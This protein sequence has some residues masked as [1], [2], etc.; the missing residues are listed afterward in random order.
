MRGIKVKL[1]VLALIGG[2]AAIGIAGVPAL[3]NGHSA[4]A[5]SITGPEV[6]YG[7]VHGKAAIVNSPIIPLQW[8]GLVSTHSS[9]NL[10]GGGPHKGSVKTLTSPAGNLTIKVTRKPHQSQ[11]FNN[12]TCQFSYTLDIRVAVSGS[13]STGAFANASGPGAVQVRFAETARRYHSGPKKGQC[14]PNS[15][16]IVKTA[17]ATFLASVVLTAR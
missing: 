13:R 12:T 5:K 11:G 8:V 1:A 17:L 4:S 3:A 7:A 6:I 16:P 2:A 9:I 15:K 14:N 10:G